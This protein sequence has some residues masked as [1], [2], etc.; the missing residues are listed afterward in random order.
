MLP[1]QVSSASTS[2]GT[3]VYVV[4]ILDGCHSVET[5][6]R[7]RGRQNRQSPRA[8][9]GGGVTIAFTFLSIAGV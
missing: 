1:Y 9:G 7:T 3:S 8:P 2:N 4:W 5:K 6:A